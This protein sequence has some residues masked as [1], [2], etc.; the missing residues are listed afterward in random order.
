M[1]HKRWDF[2][3]KVYLNCFKSEAGLNFRTENSAPACLVFKDMSLLCNALL[4]F[5]C[6]WHLP[7]GALLCGGLCIR[8]KRANRKK[9]LEGAN[10]GFNFSL[11]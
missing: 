7:S 6:L 10:I 5:G 8:L 11:V 1:L 3:V 4:S 2:A 9:A